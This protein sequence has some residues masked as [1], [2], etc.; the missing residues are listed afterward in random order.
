MTEKLQ[1]QVDG[2]EWSWKNLNT[3]NKCFLSC[4]G[5]NCT[6]FFPYIVS[7]RLNEH[8]L[9]P[10]QTKPTSCNTVGPTMSHNVGRKF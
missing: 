9:T 10:V 2:T 5:L 6:E 4:V 1:A 8:L 7:T 3:V